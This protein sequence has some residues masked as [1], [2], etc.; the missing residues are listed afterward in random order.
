MPI[1]FKKEGYLEI[2]LKKLNDAAIYPRRYFS[3]SLNTLPYLSTKVSMPISE[4]VSSNV[5]CLPLYYELEEKQIEQIC[6]IINAV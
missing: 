6:N 2:V 4:K 5:I 3:P 1:V